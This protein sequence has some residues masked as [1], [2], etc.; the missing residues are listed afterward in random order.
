M[1]TQST[2]VHYVYWVHHC[3]MRSPIFVVSVVSCE[4]LS[5]ADTSEILP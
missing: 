1:S 2:V 3:R 5:V 4:N